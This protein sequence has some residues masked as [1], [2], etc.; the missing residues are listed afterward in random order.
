MSIRIAKRNEAR[1]PAGHSS[2]PGG[3]S[4]VPNVRKS[5]S[6]PLPAGAIDGALVGALAVRRRAGLDASGRC[7]P[8]RHPMA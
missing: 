8:A 3:G 6:G 1:L 5:D 2:Q 4:F 7:A